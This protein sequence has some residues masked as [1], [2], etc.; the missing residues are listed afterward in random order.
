MGKQVEMIGK[1]F[2]RLVTVEQS[3]KDHKGFRYLFSCDCGNKIESRGALIRSGKTR[4]CGCLKS[5]VIAAKNFKHGK[6]RTPE[7]R[8]MQARTSHMKR[9]LRMPKWANKKQIKEF[10][11]NKPDGHQVDHIIPLRGKTVSGLH[12]EYNLQYLPALENMRKHNTYLTR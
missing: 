1:R 9:K 11:M 10:Y 6:S 7:Y 5:E 4:S 3:G 12:V 8:S 2:G